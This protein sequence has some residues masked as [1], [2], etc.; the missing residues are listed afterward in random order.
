MCKVG[1]YK[2]MRERQGVIVDVYKIFEGIKSGKWKDQVEAYR[3]TGDASIKDNLPCYTV[4]G[5]FYPTKA[6]EN[7]K[8]PSNLLS[9]DIDDFC[10]DHESLSNHLKIIPNSICHVS[11]SAGG[12]GFV[13]VVLIKECKDYEQFKRV[14]EAIYLSLCETGLHKVAK[15]DHLPNLNRLRFVSYDPDA[16]TCEYKYLLPFKDEA[17]IPTQVSIPIKDSTP[18]KFSVD[19]KLNNDELYKEVVTRYVNFVGEFGAA[20][21]R[22]DWVLGLARWCCRGNV[23]EGWLVSKVL[24]DYQNS[25]RA[26]VWSSEVR[27]CIR[28]SYRAYAAEKGQFEPTKKFSYIDVM[29]CTN[30]EQVREQVFGA[31]AH[32]LNYAE[33]LEKEGKSS[34]FVKE[35]INFM[36]KLTDFI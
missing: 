1:F 16:F 8:T 10:G 25:S 2:N 17:E 21:T 24:S 28:D 30:A 5:V 22:H 9:L 36:R 19:G 26:S 14:Y 15:F 29:S 13:V 35:E 12:K 3:A 4:G 34:K 7:L 23:D 11:R 31:I 18:V 6:I 33:Y 27:R 32:K 20:G